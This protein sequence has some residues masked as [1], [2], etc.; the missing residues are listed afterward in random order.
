MAASGSSGRYDVLVA[1][2]GPAGSACAIR[3]AG[4]GLRVA[5]L[6]RSHFP[7]PKACAEYFSPGV[8]DCLERL[9]AW[10]EVVAL[11]HARL[12]GM[13]IVAPS[14]RRHLVG[15][16]A[17]GGPRRALALRREALDDALLERARRA[18]AEVLAGWSATGLRRD[19][20]AVGGLLVRGPTAS[21]ELRAPLVIAADGVRSRLAR[22][23][24]LAA[25]A[26]WPA[27]LGLIAHYGGVSRLDG[28]GEMHV[29]RGV[30]AGLA[31]LG[32]G[33]VSLGLVTSVPTARRLGNAEAVLGWTLRHLPAVA[34]ALAGGRRLG[35]LRGIAPLAQRCHRPF[36]D[37]V[38]LVGDAA[39]FLDPFTGEGVFR[40]LR[41]AE[42]AA[43]VATE[44]LRR[45]DTSAAALAPY[46]AL[47]K[48][49]FGAKDRLCLLIQAFVGAPALLEYALRR[50]PDRPL[51]ATELAGALGDLHPAGRALAPGMLWALLR[52]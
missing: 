12:D 15:Y 42:L 20:T 6:D 27:R 8:V 24:G 4:A 17:D 9:G 13:E 22:D 23:L 47:R 21:T 34:A 25:P 32:N 11:P 5:L 45:G 14:G 26:R 52:P 30:Y 33:E 2:A 41:G 28:R 46:A 18:G 19:G 50:L 37:G 1:G 43:A 35:A 48:R 3:L 39:G 31:P 49:A 16:P 40:A 7:R 10:E 44:A 29:G 38:V 51:P 36:A